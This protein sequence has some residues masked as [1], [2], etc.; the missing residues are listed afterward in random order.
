[1]KIGRSQGPFND[2]ERGHPGRQLRLLSG[3]LK[4]FP[5]NAETQHPL[6]LE[7]SFRTALRL[8][9]EMLLQT[10]G[11]SS[12]QNHGSVFDARV[13]QEIAK[14]FELDN[15]GCCGRQHFSVVLAVRMLRIRL[16]APVR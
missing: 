8:V 9:A 1:M 15:R 3:T 2:D 16:L 5:D 11:R 14:D 12:K 7:Y 13:T 4:T 6:V 10:F